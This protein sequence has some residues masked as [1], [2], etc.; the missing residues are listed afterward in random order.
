M[1]PGRKTRSP[2]WVSTPAMASIPGNRDLTERLTSVYIQ[3]YGCQMN[4]ADSRTVETILLDAGYRL[5]DT[6]EAAKVILVNTCAVRES[7]QTRAL[8]QISSLSRLKTQNGTRVIGVL[9]C[10]PQEMR[11]ALAHERP[12]L[13]LVVGPDDYRQLPYLIEERLAS[14]PGEPARIATLLRRS[15]LYDD[16]P[17]HHRGGVTA[18]VTITRGCD[19]FCSYCVVPYTRGRERSRPL[20]SIVAEAE[21]LVGKGAREIMLLGQ[22]VDAYEWEDNGFPDCLKAVASVDGLERVRFLTSHPQDTGQDLFDVMAADAK[23]CPYLH[24]PVQS[25]SNRILEMMNR[26]YTRERYLEI[27]GAAKRTVP[28]LAFSTDIIVGFPSETERDFEETLDLVHQVRFDTA[29][30]FRYSPRPRTKAARLTDDVPEAEKIRRLEK[31]ISLQLKIGREQNL[32]QLGRVD[33]VL[34]EGKSPKNNDM[35]IGRT[36]DHRPVVFSQNGEMPGQVVAVKLAELRGFTF[37]GL[38]A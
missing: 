30:M 23:I 14:P 17:P 37:V 27:I 24:L 10:I 29:F 18:F 36:P 20:P 28:G 7:A 22:N 19:K 32:K 9:G 4:I 25:G 21:K 35:W 31:L 8:G 5:V 12:F 34:V 3:T 2:L 1:Q 16:I 26:G 15:E 6:P 11:E 33:D 38:R 13:D